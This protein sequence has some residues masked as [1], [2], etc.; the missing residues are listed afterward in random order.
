MSINMGDVGHEEYYSLLEVKKYNNFR[1]M[2]ML[3]FKNDNSDEDKN[4]LDL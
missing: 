4:I 2:L 3:Q 1:N